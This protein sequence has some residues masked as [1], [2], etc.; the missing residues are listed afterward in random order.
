[1]S[2]LVLDANT[3]QA[4][5]IIRSLGS[6]GI[7]VIAADSNSHALGFKSRYVKTT[8]CYPDPMKN[9]RIFVDFIRNKL[10]NSKIELVIPPTDRTLVPLE[11]ERY[12]I[13]ESVILAIP[14]REAVT[15][16]RDKT[17]TYQLSQSC[18]VPAP[19]TY[20]I[21]KNSDIANIKQISYPVVVKPSRSKVWLNGKGCELE[22]GY[23]NDRKELID[24]L[25]KMIP[26]CD[27]LIQE[28][29]QGTGCGIEILAYQGKILLAFQH[30]RLREFP[31]TGGASC[32]RE[33][34]VLNPQLFEYSKRLVNKLK[35]T[36]VLMVEFKYNEAEKKSYL[37]EING[38]FWGSLPLSV[39]S[40]VDFPYHLY[41]LLV[42]NKKPSSAKYKIGIKSRA[43]AKDIQWIET[44]FRRIPLSI[45]IKYPMRKEALK[46]LLKFWER[47]MY[48]DF[49]SFNDPLPGLFEIG[50]ICLRYTKRL[51]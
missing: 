43:L 33:S 20:C 47:N 14:S 7:E 11:K 27:V 44:V 1:M 42:K 18:G 38:R 49:Q 25:N 12:S 19:E 22:V 17:K 35:W 46:A 29:V 15:T 41:L 10:Y 48:Y 30:N 16:A 8:F 4:I 9:D 45:K 51:F 21:N 32:L 6:Q 24:Y 3:N 34:T 39:V 5:A 50:N 40:G 28:Y 36:G 26:L 31:L 13:P 23:A 37:M 2:V